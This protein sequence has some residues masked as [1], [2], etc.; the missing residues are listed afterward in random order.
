MSMNKA[1]F[2]CHN[3]QPPAQNMATCIPQ[4]NEA[5]T[6]RQLHDFKATTY[7]TQ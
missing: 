2:M 1:W 6:L 3:S 4:N 7:F 5:T